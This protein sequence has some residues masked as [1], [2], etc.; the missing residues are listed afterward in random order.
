[1]TKNSKNDI[2]GQMEFRPSGFIKK[3][4]QSFWNAKSVCDLIFVNS[5]IYFAFKLIFLSFISD[6]DADIKRR[7]EVQYFQCH[8]KSSKSILIDVKYQ[9]G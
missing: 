4:F 6:Q 5:S 3:C 1:M 9:N 8:I 7:P 2:F